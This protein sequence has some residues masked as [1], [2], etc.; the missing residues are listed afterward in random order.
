MPRGRFGAVFF[1]SG[2]VTGRGIR[3]GSTLAQL[4][5]A[6]PKLSPGRT[7]PARQPQLLSA[8]RTSPTLGATRRREPGEAR[9]AD[10]VRRTRLR[11]SRRRVRLRRS[12]VS[13]ICP[14][15]QPGHDPELSDRSCQR[16]E[17]GG[18]PGR[19]RHARRPVQMPVPAVQ[20]AAQ[21]VV[22]IGR[23]RG[24]CLPVPHADRL[25]SP[26]GGGDERPCRVPRR[27]A[28]R[29]VRGRAAHRL[30]APTAEDPRPLGG[31]NGGQDRR[32][33]LGRDLLRHPHGLSAPRCQ[34]CA[35]ARRRRFRAGTRCPGARGLPDGHA[36]QGEGHAC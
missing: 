30:P 34:P 3:I 15:D 35:R 33:R 22:G 23:R 8:S 24:A 28:R 31:S 18:S 5:R 1:R 20:D 16:G 19:S 13:T 14:H 7:D 10:R 21:G 26:E 17:L 9:D 6:Y 2:A 27:R 25:W 4:R 29:L 12:A 36:A 11:A 32:Q